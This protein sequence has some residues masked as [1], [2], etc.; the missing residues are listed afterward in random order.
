MRSLSEK[1]IVDGSEINLLLLAINPGA[2]KLDEYQEFKIFF[3]LKYQQSKP[4]PLRVQR[5]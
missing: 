5:L 1:N 3:P 4:Q 2:K